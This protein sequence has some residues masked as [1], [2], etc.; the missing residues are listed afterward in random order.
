MIRK[1]LSSILLLVSTT[2]LLRAQTTALI[3][4][5]DLAI[6]FGTVSG[7]IIVAGE[8][9]VFID[10]QKPELSF[11]IAKNE[12]ENVTIQDRTASLELSRSIQ[13][14]SGERSRLNFRLPNGDTTALTRWFGAAVTAPVAA[15]PGLSVRNK[16]QSNPAK[17]SLVVPADTIV[18]L[19]L[20]QG[21]SSRTAQRG[22]TFTAQVTAPVVVR[23]SVVIPEGAPFTGV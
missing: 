6:P 14:R 21:L 8:H 16:A 13:D 15:A 9:L 1:L 10:E 22:D 18:Q 19:K 2:S 11:V 4:K 7:K 20:N 5:A 17:Q 23:N 12:V 3:Q